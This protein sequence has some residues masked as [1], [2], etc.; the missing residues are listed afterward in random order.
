MP[1]SI[2]RVAQFHS[3][4][5]RLV[6]AVGSLPIPAPIAADLRFQPVDEAEVAEHLV[7]LA[8]GRVRFAEW[9]RGR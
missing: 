5:E 1:W 3:F 2:V 4:V 6:A 9:L 8:L 7:E